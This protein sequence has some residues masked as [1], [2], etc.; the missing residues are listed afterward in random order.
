MVDQL[1]RPDK[2]AP[3][4]RGST[5][6]PWRTARGA[7]PSVLVLLN[8]PFAVIDIETTGLDPSGDEIIEIAALVIPGNCQ[9]VVEFST[10]VKPQRL[11]PPEI[12]RLTGIEQWHLDERGMSLN[13]SLG[14]FMDFV[15]VLPLF[16]HHAEFDRAFLTRSAELCGRTVSNPM[17]DTIYIA[18]AAWPG[19]D[20]YK[21]SR[22]AEFLQMMDRPSHRALD[23]AKAAL[24]VLM[25][26][27][28]VLFDPP[29]CPKPGE[30]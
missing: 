14:Y 27:K 10:L 28:K 2:A 13:D 25:Q 24:A 6:R 26:A 22:L 16:A 7:D 30:P 3:L 20:S 18:K 15:G 9:P 1:N 23:D 21:L 11:L 29:G 5:S 4:P 19:L 17:H 12:T 8:G